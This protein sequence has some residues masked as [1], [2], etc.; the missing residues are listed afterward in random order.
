MKKSRS[1]DGSRSIKGFTLMEV[2]LVLAIMGMIMSMVIPKVMGRQ[3]HA[4]EDAT[5]LSLHGLKQAL[6]M[7]SLDHSGK[8]PTT[9]DG[10]QV[11]I[12]LPQKK[13]NRWRGPYLEVQPL[14]A[15]GNALRYVIP[16][17]RNRDSFDVYSQGEDGVD[18]TADDIYE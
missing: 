18:G 12:T 14:D 2:L 4:N 9:A 8:Y 10:L 7:Y 16:G 13:D 6:R 3:K 5:K 15:W 11:L 1:K 17:K